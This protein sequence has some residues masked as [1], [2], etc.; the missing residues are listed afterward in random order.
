M[1][2]LLPVATLVLGAREPRVTDY[3]VERR[4]VQRVQATLAKTITVS[5]AASGF[6]KVYALVPPT[7]ET[8]RLVSCSIVCREVPQAPVSEAKDRLTTDKKYR[9]V[10]VPLNPATVGRPL[11]FDI[12]YVVDLY[13][14]TLT[15][16]R[17]PRLGEISKPTIEDLR[18]TK[19]VDFKAAPYQQ[20]LN[21]LGLNKKTGE[22]VTDFAYRAFHT[23][24]DDL[25]HRVRV[26]GGPDIGSDHWN[27]SY[28]CEQHDKNMSCGLCAIQLAA[29][30]RANGVP[31]RVLVG[32]WALDQ[33]GDYGQ[34]HVRADFYDPLIGWVPVDPTFGFMGRQKG[35][36]IDRHFGGTDGNF[37]TM[38]LN[39][40]VA[41]EGTN[42]YMPIHQFEIVGYDGRDRFTPKIAETWSVKKL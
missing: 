38:H 19:T 36:N 27:A 9:F 11:H 15:P 28:L 6:L 26:D 1:V 18:A 42:F 41:P 33:Q 4:P 12:V 14:T 24:S 23:L 3:R 34:F 25:A 8:Q 22:G 13:A 35:E 37:I 7:T 40:E 32:R 29:V 20:Y 2:A 17:D 39:T 5:D 31:S 30:L 10:R 16:G 21:T